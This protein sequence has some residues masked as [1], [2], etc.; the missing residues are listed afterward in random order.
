MLTLGAAG[1]SVWRALVWPTRAARD[2]LRENS[3]PTMAARA[4]QTIM[5]RILT[6]FRF[7]EFVFMVPA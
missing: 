5:I 4:A 6:M 3:S 2:W 1:L 7:Q